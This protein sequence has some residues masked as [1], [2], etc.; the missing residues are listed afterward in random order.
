MSDE[1]KKSASGGATTHTSGYMV[2]R[3][4]IV[5]EVS[6][7]RRWTVEQKLA[8]LRDAFGPQSWHAGTC[9]GFRA[10]HL[11]HYATLASRVSGLMPPG[12]GWRRRELQKLLVYWEKAASACRQVSQRCR[13]LNSGLRDLKKVPQSCRSSCPCRSLMDADRRPAAS[14]ARRRSNM[15]CRDRRLDRWT[16][17]TSLELSGDR[18]KRVSSPAP[19]L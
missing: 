10:G 6:G 7:Q 2:S 18:H 5:S 17:S 1:I 13:P 9:N 16:S 3:I 4:E 15:D 11:F 8:V 12:F 19:G 14:F